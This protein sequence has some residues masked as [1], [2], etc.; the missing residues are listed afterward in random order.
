MLVTFENGEPLSILRSLKLF[1]GNIFPGG[2]FMFETVVYNVK[3]I[4]DGEIMS[5]YFLPRKP[6]TNYNSGKFCV[7]C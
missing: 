3:L 1:Q 7:W 2:H 4:Y 5:S 6:E